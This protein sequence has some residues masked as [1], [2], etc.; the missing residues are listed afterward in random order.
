MDWS[1]QARERLLAESGGPI[2]MCDWQDAVFLHFAV[3]RAVL[4]PIIPFPLDL[5]EG[6]AYMSLVAFDQQRFRTPLGGGVVSP[7]VRPFGSHLFCNLRTYVRL[8]ADPGIYFLREWVP[9]PVGAVF[10]PLTIGLPY[11]LSQLRYEHDRREGIFWGQVISG[12]REL[13]L[14]ARIDYD[15]QV[16]M[17]EPGSLDDFLL[18]RYT[19]FTVAIGGRR[20]KFHIW[21]PPWSQHRVQ[22]EVAEDGLVRSTG[23]WYESARLVACNYSPGV[24]GVW[25]GRP[26]LIR[27]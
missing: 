11:R 13:D 26:F 22:G 10:V 3:D 16:S 2:F 9:N 12:G 27:E 17:P 8:E 24:A 18:E 5:W 25:I 23:S 15:A 7:L 6:E 20:Q 1:Q 21:H 19:G 4:Q 14:S